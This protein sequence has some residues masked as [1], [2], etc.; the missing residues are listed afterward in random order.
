MSCPLFGKSSQLASS[1]TP[2]KRELASIS[3]RT[4]CWPCN[5]SR[6]LCL[7]EETGAS[8]Q[9][10]E[11]AC[12]AIFRSHLPKLC[13]FLSWDSFAAPKYFLRKEQVFHTAPTPS[14]SVSK[15]L[16]MAPHSHPKTVSSGECQS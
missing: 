13:L 11:E 5:T 6:A 4:G 16:Q 15:A 10:G 8:L 1:L 3:H 9:E 12:I 2:G 7:L 14:V